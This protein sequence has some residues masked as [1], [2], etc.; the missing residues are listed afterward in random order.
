ML[1]FDYDKRTYRICFSHRIFEKAPPMK[2]AKAITECYLQVKPP[3]TAGYVDA[4][5]WEYIGIARAYCNPK[6]QFVKEIGRKTALTRLLERG[7]CPAFAAKTFRA[8]LWQ[9]YLE[10]KNKVEY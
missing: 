3:G 8:P 2:A 6:D 4:D 1:T 7:K 10:R 5:G 9:A